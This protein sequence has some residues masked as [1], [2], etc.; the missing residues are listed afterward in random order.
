MSKSA[1][2][3]IVGLGP[4]DS[5]ILTPQAADVLFRAGAVVGYT[6]YLGLIPE[7]ATPN[8]ERIAAGMR[9]ERD[10]ARAAVDSALAGVDTVVVS[11]GDAGIYGMAGLVLQVLERR[12]LLETID[13]EVVPGVPALSAAAA[14]LGAP[15]MH[16]FAC[17][18]LSDLLTPMELI[19]KRLRAAAR[20]DFVIVL[21]NPRSKGRPEHLATALSIIKEEQQASTP[22]GIVR[23]AYREGQE[24]IVT[25]LAELDTSRVDMTSIVVIGNSQSYVA[26]GRIITPRGYFQEGDDDPRRR[27]S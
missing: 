20:A 22:A 25:T 2:L 11:S 14:L 7:E 13:C 6:T 4:G 5:S 8:A 27:A 21:Y 9:K 23:S 12:G 18:S 3:S 24:I 26:G 15:L 17:I 16:D 10:R 1:K 19:K